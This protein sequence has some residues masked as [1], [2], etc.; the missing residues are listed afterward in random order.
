MDYNNVKQMKTL[1]SYLLCCDIWGL[2]IFRRVYKIAD[3]GY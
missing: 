3:S 2:Y 1:S